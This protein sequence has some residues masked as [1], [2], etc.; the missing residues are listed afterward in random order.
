MTVR[1]GDIRN[2]IPNNPF[3]KKRYGNVQ[4][5]DIRDGYV[6]YVHIGNSLEQQNKPLISD[7]N[8]SLSS[9][10]FDI[11]YDQLLVKG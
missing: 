6:L 10:I 9:V 2:V 5:L 1:I 11:V 7:F 3:D 8:M 4:V